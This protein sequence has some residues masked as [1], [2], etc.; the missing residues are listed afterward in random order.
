VKIYDRE[1]NVIEI[2]DYHGRVLNDEAQSARI[3]ERRT[4]QFRLSPFL[5]WAAWGG[6][7]AGYVL[8]VFLL[9]LSML[10]WAMNGSLH[11]SSS[12]PWACGIGGVIALVVTVAGNYSMVEYYKKHGVPKSLK[13]KPVE[14]YCKSCEKRIEEDLEVAN[15]QRRAELLIELDALGGPPVP[16]LEAPKDFQTGGQVTKPAG[17]D[18]VGWRPPKESPFRK[19]H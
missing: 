2:K 18:V 7:I 19:D 5:F 16:A 15:E 14:L 4:G 8:T 11:T 13:E 9:G 6:V 12:Q 10:L 17:E 1:G 3:L